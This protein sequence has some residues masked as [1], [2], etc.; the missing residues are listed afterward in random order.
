MKCQ[1]I[2]NLIEKWQSLH[3]NRKEADSILAFRNAAVS[4]KAGSSL[5]CEDSLPRER[6]HILYSFYFSPNKP[7]PRTSLFFF[8]PELTATPRWNQLSPTGSL[9]F[10]VSVLLVPALTGL[11]GCKTKVWIHALFSHPPSL[12]RRQ[13]PI[14]IT[15]PSLIYLGKGGGREKKRTGSYRKLSREE[16]IAA[17]VTKGIKEVIP[18]AI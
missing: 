18:R 7:L 9:L 4:T 15:K 2:E 14:P 8:F 5:K 17:Q 13:N 11:A 12:P 6:S 3:R 10:S 16:N 1:L